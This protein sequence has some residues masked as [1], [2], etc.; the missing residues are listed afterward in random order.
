MSN[1]DMDPRN[2][3]GSHVELR[4]IGAL[5][6][7]ARNSRIHSKAQVAQISRSIEQWGF[8]TPVLIDEA[9]GIIAGHGRVLAAQKLKITELP[10]II[11]RGW[12]D[13]KKRA[14]VIADNKLALN[15][16][17]DDDMLREELEAIA[18]GDGD[19]GEPEVSVDMLGFTD[20]ELR[21]LASELAADE[22]ADYPPQFQILIECVDE[23]EQL[24]LLERLGEEGVVCRALVA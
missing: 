19:D 13:A 10:C 11:A 7:Y 24:R 5:I 12:S 2:W 1:A 15:A 22:P 6:P 8:T 17:W 14:Y 20:K 18:R 3:P 9:G 4:A 16:D 23:A 21:L